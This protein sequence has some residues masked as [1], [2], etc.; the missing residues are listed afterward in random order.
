MAAR[1]GVVLAL[2]VQAAPITVPV[3]IAATTVAGVGDVVHVDVVDTEDTAESGVVMPAAEISASTDP[4]KYILEVAKYRSMCQEFHERSKV[5]CEA[6]LRLT[7][8]AQVALL[9][10]IVQKFLISRSH[11]LRK[12][13][14]KMFDV[15]TGPIRHIDPISN[16]HDGELFSIDKNIRSILTTHQKQ[17]LINAK[18]YN[19]V[20]YIGFVQL[21]EYIMVLKYKRYFRTEEITICTVI[22]EYG[23]VIELESTSTDDFV[24]SRLFDIEKKMLK[25]HGITREDGFRLIYIDPLPVPLNGYNVN[26]A[27]AHSASQS[28]VFSV[29]IEGKNMK[30]ITETIVK[31]LEE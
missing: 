31:E 28:V 4:V 11:V 14:C 15:M 19:E 30:V 13:I 27:V 6:L 24:R 23:N 9:F 16:K 29:D 12:L 1:R 26:Y 20:S 8:F 25:D 17:A 7:W 22:I 3:P 18:I 2:Q 21:G 5:A 10:E